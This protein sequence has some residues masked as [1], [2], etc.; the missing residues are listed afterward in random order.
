M[1]CGDCRWTQVVDEELH[2]DA[3]NRLLDW[4]VAHPDQG[5]DHLSDRDFGTGGLAI[6][7]Y[8]RWTD[9]HGMLA[10][11]D[12]RTGGR[13]RFNHECLAVVQAVAAGAPLDDA[14]AANANRL[15]ISRRKA[16]GDIVA[17]AFSLFRKG[18]LWP[19][20]VVSAGSSPV[21]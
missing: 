11:G 4:H 16:Q 19:A 8:V 12:E 2:E 15:G 1:A 17:V 9:N 21:L 14:V 3:T 7:P 5:F 20:G 13:S 6:P 10:I 18:L